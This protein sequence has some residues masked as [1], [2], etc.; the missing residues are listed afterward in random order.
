MEQIASGGYHA[1]A[2]ADRMLSLLRENE[3]SACMRTG[4]SE[5][6]SHKSS[7][8]FSRYCKALTLRSSAIWILVYFCLLSSSLKIRGGGE[9]EAAH[10]SRVS[11][12]RVD[13]QNQTT[14]TSQVRSH[15]GADLTPKLLRYRTKNKNKMSADRHFGLALDASPSSKYALK[16]AIDNVFK[17][18]DHLILVVVHREVLEGGQVH[19]WG[20]SGSR[21]S[22]DELSILSPTARFY[23]FFLS[24]FLSGRSFSSDLLLYY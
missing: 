7:G 9:G 4:V 22:H 23:L 11:S 3:P 6:N 1:D 8:H 2:V 20:K 21:K 18:G 16:W 19:L 5:D 17:E 14:R 12:L 24:F 10:E 13:R 15:S